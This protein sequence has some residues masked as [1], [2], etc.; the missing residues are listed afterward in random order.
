M[1]EPALTARQ[2]QTL[3]ARQALARK[4]ATPQEKSDYYRTLGRK[5]AAGRIVLSGSDAAALV[6]L[7][8]AATEGSVALSGEAATSLAAIYNL[9]RRIA[10][11]TNASEVR[12]EV[13][14]VAA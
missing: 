9:L 3:A 1:S 5:A 13:V 2:R 12:R 11:R 7:G 8:R 14:D 4:F 6:H 10:Q